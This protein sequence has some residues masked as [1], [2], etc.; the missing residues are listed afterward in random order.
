MTRGKDR[1]ED[2]LPDHLA[3]WLD[4]VRRRLYAELAAE[5]TEDRVG[6]LPELR[7]SHRRLLQMVPPDGIRITDLAKRAGMTKQSLGEF[8]DYL[9]QAHYL[10]SGP[11]DT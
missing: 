6:D 11:T 5:F 10:T 7:G 4:A 1:H 9:E 8:V 3:R 2:F